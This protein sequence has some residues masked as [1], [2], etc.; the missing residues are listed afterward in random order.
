VYLPE[1]TLFPG[2]TEIELRSSLGPTRPGPLDSRALGFAAYGID[3]DVT[4]IDL[5]AAR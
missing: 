5:A 3:L 1:V 4:P 2:K